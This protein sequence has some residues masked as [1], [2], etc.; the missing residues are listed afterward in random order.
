MSPSS[1]YNYTQSA[2]LFGCKG[3]QLDKLIQIPNYTEAVEESGKGEEETI[4]QED[5]EEGF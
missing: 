1:S 5:E 2:R 3:L 4:K